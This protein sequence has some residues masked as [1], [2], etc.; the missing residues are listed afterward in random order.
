MQII[1]PTM[2]PFLASHHKDIKSEIDE[3]ASLGWIAPAF[4]FSHSFIAQ[5]HMGEICSQCPIAICPSRDKT[6]VRLLDQIFTE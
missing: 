1:V 3:R 6:G 2:H 5:S 4:R